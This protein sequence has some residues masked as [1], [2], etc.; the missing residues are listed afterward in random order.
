M[1]GDKILRRIGRT[2]PRAM[3]TIGTPDAAAHKSSASLKTTAEI[4][5][6]LTTIRHKLTTTQTQ[7]TFL[8]ILPYLPIPPA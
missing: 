7:L 1:Q 8:Q 4:P 2:M 6:P 5:Q 3:V